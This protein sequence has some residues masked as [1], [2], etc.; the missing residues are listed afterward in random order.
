MAEAEELTWATADVLQRLFSENFD[1]HGFVKPDGVPV[2]AKGTFAVV[3]KV[4]SH[5]R[6][7][8]NLRILGR[9]V[10]G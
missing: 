10:L 7:R 6:I 2:L 4:F 1:S 3:F 5:S 8:L 9:R